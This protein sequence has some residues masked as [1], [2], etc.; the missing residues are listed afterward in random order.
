MKLILF[1]SPKFHVFPVVFS[2][3]IDKLNTMANKQ[4][5]YAP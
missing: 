1:K 4:W 5:S 3:E 2:E